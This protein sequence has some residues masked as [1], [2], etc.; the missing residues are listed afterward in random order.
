[1]T[2]ADVGACREE[3]TTRQD[4]QREG[5]G[6]RPKENQ[7]H[8]APPEGVEHR[9]SRERGNGKEEMVQKR[10]RGWRAKKKQE[11]TSWGI[12]TGT[13]GSGGGASKKGPQQVQKEPHHPN[14]RGREGSDQ[15]Q[16]HETV[17]GWMRIQCARAKGL[18]AARW[19]I[20][21]GCWEKG[22][23]HR[24]ACGLGRTTAPGVG[25]GAGL[26]E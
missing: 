19:G 11:V 1:M 17:P 15:C 14:G 5:G 20:N 12:G 23:G 25:E 24:R 9:A 8:K 4:A 26:G 22:T 7:N 3:G 18:L 16:G 13:R 2:S 21:T 6:G 10:G